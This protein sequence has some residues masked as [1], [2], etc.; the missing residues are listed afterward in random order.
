MINKQKDFSEKIFDLFIKSQEEEK[1][2]DE[3]KLAATPNPSQ[4]EGKATP[5]GLK[6]KLYFIEE[7]ADFN[8][9]SVWPIR[10]R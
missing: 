3:A 10:R 1:R 8:K 9:S 4:A 2:A 5:H 6:E 7:P